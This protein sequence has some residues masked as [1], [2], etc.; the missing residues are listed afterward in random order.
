MYGEE[1]DKLYKAI[2]KH[3]KNQALAK[4]SKKIKDDMVI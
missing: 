1:S 3:P 4:A 2:K